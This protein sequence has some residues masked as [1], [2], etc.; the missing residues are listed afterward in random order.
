MENKMTVEVKRGDAVL[1]SHEISRFNTQENTLS[2]CFK[3]VQMFDIPM[4][5]DGVYSVV[6]TLPQQVITKTCI[7]VSYNYIVFSNTFTQEDGSKETSLDCSDNS[8]LFR[9]IG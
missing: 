4:I 6:I 5:F 7:F 1:M 8:L 3:S 2:V 9:V